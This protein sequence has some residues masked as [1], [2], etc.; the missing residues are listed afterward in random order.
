MDGSLCSCQQGSAI[1]VLLE[2]S[3]A[4][5]ESIIK[6]SRPRARMPIT[7]VKSSVVQCLVVQNSAVK[8]SLV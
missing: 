4:G 7:P 1:V 8:F 3:G 6:K 2:L 5:V